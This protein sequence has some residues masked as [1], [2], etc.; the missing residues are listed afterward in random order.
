[1]SHHTMIF[2]INVHIRRISL[3]LLAAESKQWGTILKLTEIDWR[4]KSGNIKHQT[5][6][7]WQLGKYIVVYEDHITFELLWVFTPTDASPV[8]VL[9]INVNEVTCFR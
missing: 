3:K 8:N 6:I 9:C 7:K 2:V 1:M 4:N 5:Q